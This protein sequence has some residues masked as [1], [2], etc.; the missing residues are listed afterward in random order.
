MTLHNQPELSDTSDIA[1]VDGTWAVLI[2]KDN[3]GCRARLQ[4]ALA[5]YTFPIKLTVVSR[6]DELLN[7]LASN[8]Y[9]LA[10]VDIGLGTSSGLD[11]VRSARERGMG[12]FVVVVSGSQTN[13]DREDARALGAYDF[14]DKPVSEADVHRALDAFQRVR[15]RS[16]ALLID[17]S[18]TAR[19]LMK[20]IFDRSIFRVDVLEAGD[21]VEGIEVFARAPT[22]FVFV[23]LHMGGI[24]GLA[25]ARVIRAINPEA[26]VVI[27]SADAAN[28]PKDRRYRT[29]SKPFG[30]R[31]LNHLLHELNGIPHPLL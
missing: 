12:T 26:K 16:T 21:G 17:D 8:A 28:L 6:A 4:A 13:M 29:L 18:G 19:R 27:V 25:T 23:D 30:A 5:C 20:R 3:P 24:D 2:A 9:D 14:I 1:F 11:A 15:T 10:F 31:Q 22:D 7:A